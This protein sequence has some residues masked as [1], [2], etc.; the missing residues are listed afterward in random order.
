[1]LWFL[2]QDDDLSTIMEDDPEAEVDDMMRDV[3]SRP[4][5]VPFR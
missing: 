4:T 5:T 1:M 2:M 3:P